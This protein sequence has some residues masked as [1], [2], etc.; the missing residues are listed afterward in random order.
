MLHPDPR[1]RETLH[2][3]ITK[4]GHRCEGGTPSG[5]TTRLPEIDVLFVW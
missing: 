5:S 4:L 3:S 2:D 1:L